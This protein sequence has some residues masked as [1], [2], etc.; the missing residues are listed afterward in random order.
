M[1][2]GVLLVTILLLGVVVPTTSMLGSEPL[3]DLQ[4]PLSNDIRQS[5]AR[6]PTYAVS[7]ANGLT[8]GGEEITI[9][10]S[11]FNDTL[12]GGTGNDTISGGAGTDIINGGNGNDI[13]YAVSSG[14]S[15]DATF[16][17]WVL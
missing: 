15:N 5:E 13:L 14:S 7:P 9:T 1:R 2:L 8:T 3:Q 12:T 4:P 6:S 17:G 16:N 10:G 11:G